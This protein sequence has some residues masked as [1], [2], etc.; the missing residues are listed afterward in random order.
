MHDSDR[1]LDIHK[2]KGQGPVKYD[3]VR[4]REYF[5]SH[6]LFEDDELRAVADGQ[7]PWAL[8]AYE[9]R[10]KRTRDDDDASL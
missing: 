1:Q 2:Y 10:K 8:N 7:C 9:R 6:I 3:D 5:L 4:D